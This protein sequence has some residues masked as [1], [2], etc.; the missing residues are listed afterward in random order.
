MREKPSVTLASIC[1][2]LQLFTESPPFLSPDIQGGLWLAILANLSPDSEGYMI[3]PSSALSSCDG[4]SKDVEIPY[5]PRYR[6]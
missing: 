5:C 6:N 4:D 2:P 1:N 3:N